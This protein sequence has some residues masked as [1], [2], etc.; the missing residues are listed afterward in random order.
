MCAKSCS[1]SRFAITRSCRRFFARCSFSLGKRFILQVTAQSVLFDDQRQIP[2]QSENAKH[3]DVEAH[4]HRRVTILNFIERWTRKVCPGTD[5]LHGKT[6]AKP[7][8][9]DALPQ[10]PQLFCRSGVEWCGSACHNDNLY[11]HYNDNLSIIIAV[12][13]YENEPGLL[14]FNRQLFSE[15]QAL[16]ATVLLFLKRCISHTSFCCWM[17][18][19]Q[20]AMLIECSQKKLLTQRIESEPRQFIQVL[21][22]PR[23]VGKTTVAYS[24]FPITASRTRCY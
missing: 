1:S 20:K 24:Y 6:A 5:G 12:I 16:Y 14:T 10:S 8:I 17:F 22:C 15:S 18:S 13:A 21:Y 19:E 2:E 11:L 9:P 4:S 3:L 7:R 23:Q